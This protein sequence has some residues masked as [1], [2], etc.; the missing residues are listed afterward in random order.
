MKGMWIFFEWAE[1]CA[2]IVSLYGAL[3]KSTV[4]MS[5]AIPQKILLVNDFLYTS[6]LFHN[7]RNL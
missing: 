6:S 4:G 1:L 5:G 7:G 2:S 3:A